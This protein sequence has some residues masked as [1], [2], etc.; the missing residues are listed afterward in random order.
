MSDEAQVQAMFVAAVREF[1]TIDILASNA[2]IQRDGPI[3]E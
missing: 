1:G 2:G 3:H